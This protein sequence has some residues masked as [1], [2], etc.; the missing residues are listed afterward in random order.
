MHG[1]CIRND[2]F[3]KQLF[4]VFTPELSSGKNLISGLMLHN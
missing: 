3:S 1:F 4:T 2:I